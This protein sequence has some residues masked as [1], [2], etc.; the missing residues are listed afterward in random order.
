MINLH[1]L[2]AAFVSKLTW[3]IITNYGRFVL[4]IFF[5]LTGAFSEDYGSLPLYGTGSFF[6]ITCNI[7]VI[8]LLAQFAWVVMRSV[9]L[10]LYNKK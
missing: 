8:I 2:K 4:G 3:L 1:Q 5:A 10:Y 9:Y 6:A 7:G